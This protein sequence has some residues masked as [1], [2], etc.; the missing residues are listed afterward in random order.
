M[1]LQLLLLMA[2][3]SF[4]YS[5]SQDSSDYQNIDTLSFYAYSLE[6]FGDNSTAYSFR[7][8]SDTCQI[9]FKSTESTIPRFFASCSEITKELFDS[10][11]KTK[12]NMGNCKPCVLNHINK[13]GETTIKAIQYQDCFVGDYLEYYENGQLKTKGNYKRN[14]TG[15]WRKIWKRGLCSVK[16]GEWVYYGKTGKESKREFYKNNILVK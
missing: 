4:K 8:N 7:S 15:K 11:K 14:Y 3:F 10:L 1:K 5:Q 12:Q 6:S 16:E 13:S 2:L 9:T